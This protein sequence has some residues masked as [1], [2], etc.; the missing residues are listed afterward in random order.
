M[1]PQRK[2]FNVPYLGFGIGLRP[3]HYK[4]LLEN[5]L[6]VDWLEI[7]SENFLL[8]GGRSLY[9]LDAF[10]E[11]YQLV[12][13][14]VSLS[15]GSANPLEETYLT[16]LKKLITKTKSPWFSDHLCWSNYKGKSYHN[17]MP[18]PYTDAIIDY[19]SQ[20]I[21]MVQDFMEKPFL[22]ENVSSYVEFTDSTMPEWEFLV[23]IAE[24]ADCGLLLDINNIYVS[25]RNHGFDPLA[26][27]NAIPPE[28]VIQYHIA[29]HDDKGSYVLDS[30]DHPVRDEVWELY[31]KAI[32]LFG[33]TSLM[34]E[35]DDHIPPLPDL[36]KE[37]EYA[38]KIH[39]DVTR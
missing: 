35:R 16:K 33:N 34:I 20:R 13:H 24:K 8:E 12:P 29:G 39:Q 19:V 31:A 22:L 6:S 17:L 5:P 37:L 23:R 18:L 27:L 25:S 26:Y 21:R 1:P 36:L 30:H 3:V 14:G 10:C 2:K 11:Q 15:I 7:I 28:R 4:D 9:Y 32:P 38:K